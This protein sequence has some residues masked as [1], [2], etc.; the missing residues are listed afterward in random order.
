M[1]AMVDVSAEDKSPARGALAP[2]MGYA[3]EA[4]KPVHPTAA[5]VGFDDART[6]GVKPATGLDAT[7]GFGDAKLTP[8][9]TPVAKP[10]TGFDATIGFSDAKP[11]APRTPAL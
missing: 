10:A 5:T 3:G 6:S 8:P 2:T 1:G 11:T 9:R 4:A 7:I